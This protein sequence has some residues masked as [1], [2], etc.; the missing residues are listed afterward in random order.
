MRGATACLSGMIFALMLLIVALPQRVADDA[1]HDARNGRS[2]RPARRRGKHRR[3][4]GHSRGH[5]S[6]HGD[7][8]AAARPLPLPSAPSEPPRSAARLI[9]PHVPLADVALCVGG[10]LAFDVTAA[11][12]RAAIVD[13]LRPDIFLAG[14]I[15]ANRSEVNDTAHWER[16]TS[17]AIRPLLSLGPFA[18]VSVEPQPS[19]AELAEALHATPHWD[20][21]A[22]QSSANGEG[23]LSPKDT[24]PRLWLPSMLSPV[25]GN[26]GGNTMREF[27]YQSRCHALIVAREKRRAGTYSRVMFTRIEFE[28]LQPHP[29]LSLLEPGYV[30]IPAGED[31]DGLNDRHWVASRE[32][33]RILLGR[34]DALLDG[35][36][37]RAVHGAVSGGAVRPAWLSS[38]MYSLKLVLMHRLQVGRFPNF[39]YLQ[40]CEALYVDAN[41]RHIH[42]T[43]WGVL[44]TGEGVSKG[45]KTCFQSHCNRKRCPLSKPSR[46][47]HPGLCE[48]KY[49]DE[50]SS[51]IINSELIS[52]PGA[53]LRR[54]PGSPARVEVYLRRISDGVEAN[55]FF[56]MRCLT[57]GTTQVQGCLMGSYERPDLERAVRRG[58]RC[59]TYD[60]PTMQLV[61]AS[62]ARSGDKPDHRGVTY[63][64]QYFPWWFRGAVNRTSAEETN[65]LRTFLGLEPIGS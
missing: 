35:S 3:G 63:A 34:W 40:C 32:G 25:F 31:N 7:N 9:D 64:E 48:F 41:G 8:A 5:R 23:R 20:A 61:S 58:H 1:K 54:A 46:Q 15:S 26:P 50:G 24:D 43:N 29:P 17:R 10:F 22:K 6:L 44:S 14:T 59:K 51:A 39:A 12:I 27:H 37:L 33:A 2:L 49:D 57:S 55:F 65:Q 52:L 45:A 4:G 38:E 16:R 18:A 19:V 11:S 28:W 62:L 36:A 30:W 60:E 21:Y 53:K 13:T 47:P 42:S 56:C